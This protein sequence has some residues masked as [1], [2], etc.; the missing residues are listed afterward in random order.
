MGVALVVRAA[1]VGPRLRHKFQCGFAT[2]AQTNF[3]LV[4]NPAASRCLQMPNGQF[5]LTL[6]C[7]HIFAKKTKKQNQAHEQKGGRNCLR[8]DGVPGSALSLPALCGKA[9]EEG[10]DGTWAWLFQKQ[11]RVGWGSERAHLFQIHERDFW[12]RV[13]IRCRSA[14]GEK[15]GGGV[16]LGGGAS[17]SQGLWL[18][19]LVSPQWDIRTVTPCVQRLVVLFD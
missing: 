2:V 17:E 12:G 8:E 11:V 6:A 1:S 14:G 13:C 16:G 7:P 15:N 10:A 5:D 19:S 3:V 9:K 18:R 4:H